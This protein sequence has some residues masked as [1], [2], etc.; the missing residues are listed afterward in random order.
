M[1]D[2]HSFV[3]SDVGKVIL[4]IIWG[5]GCAALFTRACKDRSC[6]IIQYRGPKQSEIEESFYKYGNSNC[7]KFT[8]YLWSCD[9]N[10]VEE[11]KKS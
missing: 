5:L 7:Y 9:N 2:F 10:P 3:Y 4:S 11:E 8:P 6:R 1:I